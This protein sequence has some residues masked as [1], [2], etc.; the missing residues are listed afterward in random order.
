MENERIYRHPSPGYTLTLWLDGEPIKQNGNGKSNAIFSD[1]GVSIDR[2][3]IFRTKEEVICKAIEQSK[4]FKQGH[5]TKLASS[6][7]IR[8]ES[9]KKKRL[10]VREVTVEMVKDGLFNLDAL[11]AYKVDDLKK[12]AES[13]GVEVSTSKGVS[14]TKADIFK[15]VK[16]ILFPG[17][18]EKKVVSESDDKEDKE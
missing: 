1:T 13:I 14:K 6:E 11:E 12:F 16:V 2:C 9:L 4:G 10:A 17:A 8:I 7:D 5:I 18:V 3:G 15:D